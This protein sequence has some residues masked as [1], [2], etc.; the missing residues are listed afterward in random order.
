MRLIGKEAT[1]H[2][3]NYR[4]KD[5]VIGVGDVWE[6]R[7]VAKQNVIEFMKNEHQEFFG[8]VGMLFDENGIDEKARRLSAFDSSCCDRLSFN[9]IHKL[10]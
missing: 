5:E 3:I 1:K 10:E 4:I 7:C 2:G 9:D 8:C 6:K